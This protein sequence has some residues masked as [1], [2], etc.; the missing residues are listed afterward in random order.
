MRYE[1]EVGARTV[2]DALAAERGGADRVELY[3][4]P[5]EGALTPSA[6]LIKGAAEAVTDLKLFVMIRPRAGDF[7]YS[8]GEFETIERDVDVALEMGA[9]GIMCGILDADGDLDTARMKSVIKRCCGKP[10][11]LHRA[12]DFSRDPLCTLEQAVDLGCT[13]VL[14]MGQD[15]EA[16]FSRELRQTILASAAGRIDV[17]IALGADFD[18]ARELEDVVRDTGAGYYHVVNGYRQRASHMRWTLDGDTES[19]YLRETMFSID[20]L[21]EQAVGEVR[22]LLDACEAKGSAC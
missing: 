9:D 3:S 18:T 11:T 2:E 17:V 14:T 20:Y 6:G 13:Y 7:L 19:D 21:C 12:F 16:L 22:D 5:L 10:F 15:R 4:S 1:L 8:R